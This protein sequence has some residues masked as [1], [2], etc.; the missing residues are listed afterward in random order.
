MNSAV[1]N[2]KVEPK[3]KKEAQRVAEKLGMSLSAIINAYLNQLVRTKTIN[4]SVSDEEPSEYLIEML[5][6]SQEDI[7]AGRVSPTFDNIED[8]I[9]W[10]NDPNA[11]YQNGDKV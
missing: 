3:L 9:A 2:I 1:V 5:R 10:L 7:K 4:F 11:R 8:E 6:K